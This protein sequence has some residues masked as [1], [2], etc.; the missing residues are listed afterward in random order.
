MTGRL[1]LYWIPLGAGTPVVRISGKIYEGLLALVK[2][3]DRRDLYHAALVAETG[4]GRTIVEVAPIP[5]D[6]GRVER[7]VVA[8]GIVGS[9]L[10][11]RLRLFRYEV[12]C[13]QN[14]TIPDLGHAVASPVCVTSRADTVDQVLELLRLV[15]TPVWGRDEFE[16]GEMWNSNSVVSWV[17]TKAQLGEAAGDPPP[18]GRAPGWQA[19]IRVATR[20]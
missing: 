15:P 14:G 16:T 7:G 1:D 5:D 20:P 9:R 11:G 2:R 12:R 19:G 13:W 8:E 17:L 6:R 4:S 10:L 3:R 18:N